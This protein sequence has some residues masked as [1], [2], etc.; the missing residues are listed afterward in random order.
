MK[1]S[2]TGSTILALILLLIGIYIAYKL[3]RIVLG[4]LS[5][6]VVSLVPILWIC[7]CAVAIYFIVKFAIQLF[8]K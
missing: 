6:A 8:K 4:L 2:S 1:K 5:E 7:V 3:V